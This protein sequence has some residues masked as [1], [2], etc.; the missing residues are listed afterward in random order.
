MLIRVGNCE[1]EVKVA[2]MMSCPRL[3]FT[4]NFFCVSQAL[5]PHGIAPTK[6]TGAFWS[7]CLT[8]CMEQVI[9][10]HDVVLTFDYDT[11]FTAKTVEALLALM[12]WSGYDA[13]APL[14]TKREANAVMF[15]LPGTT[16]DE[17]TTVDGGFFSKP[18][19]HVE[20]AHF[21]CTFIRTAAIKKMTKPWF[22]AKPNENGTWDGGHLDE[23]I[24]FWKEFSKAGNKL[25][26]ATNIS[27]G[28]CELMITW[29][30]RTVEGGKVHQHTTEFWN[31][32]RE[33]PKDVWGY[34][35]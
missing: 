20:S 25:G 23:D 34:V 4:D 7:Q 8:R 27:V 31:G 3:G 35:K 21:G 9:D 18:V 30:S 33:P 19:Q 29:P 24:S 16:A 14:Q 11:V 26:L 22:C 2:A 15:A 13:I 5:A 17:K 32:G 10:T 28:H 12:M 1:A 6:Y